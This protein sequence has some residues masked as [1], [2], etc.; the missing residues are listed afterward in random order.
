MISPSLHQSII[1]YND[2]LINYNSNISLKKYI[3]RIHNI[4]CILENWTNQ[5]IIDL[6]DEL[7]NTTD[8]CISYKYLEIYDIIKLEGSNNILSLIKQYKFKENVDYISLKNVNYVVRGITYFSEEQHFFFT[9]NA[10]KISLIACDIN[11]PYRLS[12]IR[13]EEYIKYY[14]NL[15]IQILKLREQDLLKKLK[16][17]EQSNKELLEL[18]K[19]NILLNKNIVIITSNNNTSNEK[20]LK[21]YRNI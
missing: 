13:L 7:L 6:L 9:S 5:I 4:Q 3:T 19:L 12:Y 21:Y 18:N 17:L 15:Q 10:F 11:T 16:Y 20:N 2:E 8:C 1:T 14:N